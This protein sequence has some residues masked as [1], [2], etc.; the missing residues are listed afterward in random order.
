MSCCARTTPDSPSTATKPATWPESRPTPSSAGGTPKW[1]NS[2]LQRSLQSGYEVHSPS[3]RWKRTR[4]PALVLLQGFNLFSSEHYAPAKNLMFKDSTV[5]LVKLPPNT[6]S[7]LYLGAG[8]MSI[9]RSLKRGMTLFP[10]ISIS[11]HN[12]FP[13]IEQS[14]PRRADWWLYEAERRLLA[15]QN[16]P[17]PPGPLP[18]NGVPWDMLRQQSATRGASTAWT[19]MSPPSSARLLPRSRSA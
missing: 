12:F 9:I 5:Q 1:Q 3:P 7:F 14:N 18:L 6:D 10:L 8:Y 13:R 11:L 19:A 15:F 4:L 17:R 16:R 2:S